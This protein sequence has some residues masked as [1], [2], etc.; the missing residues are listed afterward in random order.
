MKVLHPNQK[1]YFSLL[2][3]LK[4][5]YFHI[6]DVGEPQADGSVKTH[7]KVKKMEFGPVVRGTEY[8]VE[9]LADRGDYAL[10]S[11]DSGPG[12]SISPP[13]SASACTCL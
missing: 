9:V 4:K 8:T 6:D 13:R 3:Q 5:D 12:T 1:R 2:A 7:V 11:R 10:P